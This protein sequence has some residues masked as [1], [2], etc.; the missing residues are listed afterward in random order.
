MKTHRNIDSLTEIELEKEL[1]EYKIKDFHGE[2][3]AIDA[4][5]VREI[6]AALHAIDMARRM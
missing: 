6:K 3:T 1:A 5:R 4:A 2:L